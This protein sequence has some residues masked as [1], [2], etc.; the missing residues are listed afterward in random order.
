MNPLRNFPDQTANWIW[1]S[2]NARNGAPTYIYII[3][4]K[5]FEGYA[6]L[7]ATIHENV[8]D[9]CI[10]HVNDV[11]LSDEFMYYGKFN[12]TM[13]AINTIR[14]YAYNTNGAAGMIAAVY[15]QTNHILTHTDLTWLTSLV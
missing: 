2:P 10:V 1:N 11:R 5:S 8:D 12:S 14:I 3:F 15:N 6:G 4:W 7:N 9:A 13:R